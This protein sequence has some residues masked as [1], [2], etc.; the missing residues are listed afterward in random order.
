MAEKKKK[1]T[2]LWK[3]WLL[4]FFVLLLFFSISSFLTLFKIGKAPDDSEKEFFRKLPNYRDGRFLNLEPVEINNRKLTKKAGFFRFIF[5]SPNAPKR[6][7]PRKELIRAS[8]PDKP[9]EFNVCW[10]GHSSLIFEL[11]GRRFMV[12]PVFGNAAPVPWVV[13]RFVPSPLPAGELPELDFVVI[14]HD[15]YDHLEYSTIRALRNKKFPVITSLGVGA[16]LR[17]WGIPKKRI[18]EMNWNNYT[19]VAGV[20]IHAHPAR[21]FSGR[22]FDDRFSTLWSSFSFERNGKK[23]FFELTADTVSISPASAENTVPSIWYAWKSMRGTNAG[24]TTTVFPTKSFRSSKI[25]AGVCC[26]RYIGEF[27]IWQCIRIM[28]Q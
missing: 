12:D 20:K 11:G 9:E 1:K 15:H 2:H 6:A 4:S 24:R 7:Y 21:H 5:D 27:L 14:S 19:T 26:C 23:I 16:R 25:Y 3:I 22:S 28:S 10:L 17:S 13:K 18:I 8:F